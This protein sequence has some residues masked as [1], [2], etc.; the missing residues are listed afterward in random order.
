MNVVITCRD[1]FETFFREFFTRLN[2]KPDRR[3]YFQQSV[4]RLWL[5]AKE[6]GL[7][8]SHFEDLLEV[9]PGFAFLPFLWKESIAKRVTIFEGESFELLDF[10]TVYRDNG[11]E[12]KYG[13]LFRIFGERDSETNRLPFESDR[14]D[15]VI[16]WETME[17]FN[18]NPIP[19]LQELLRITRAGGLV[20]L[21]VPNQ[22]KLD[23]RL[24]LLLGKTVRTPVDH[25]FLQL[26]DRNR[27]KY[28]P[29]WREYTLGELCELVQRVGF[30]IVKAKHLNVFMNRESV[31]LPRAVGR[32]AVTLATR[33]VP[34][35]S[36][37]CVVQIQKG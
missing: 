4:D 1:D 15:G 24:R 6:F 25:Y 34:S 30:R 13:D 5:T 12:A 11:I 35:F 9:G 10:E 20:N 17:H 32:R 19:F 27:M 28:A 16:C 3:T 14:F 22:A 31:S 36:A 21:T 7:F 23:A 29:H 26:D 18:F 2:L 33:L 37:L 8:S